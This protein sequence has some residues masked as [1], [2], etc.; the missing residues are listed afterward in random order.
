[1]NQRWNSKS[2][3]VNRNWNI[4]SD[5]HQETLQSRCLGQRKVW[6]WFLGNSNVVPFNLKSLTDSVPHKPILSPGPAVKYN[7]VV[8][9][10]TFNAHRQLMDEVMNDDRAQSY[11]FSE[12][13][14]GHQVTLL[15]RPITSRTESDA[16]AA[17]SEING[18]GNGD[19]GV[20]VGFFGSGLK[21]Y[22]C[23]PVFC[24]LQM[25]NQ[26]FWSS[27]T[28]NLSPDLPLGAGRIIQMLYCK[29]TFSSMSQNLDCW[30]VK[31]TFL[32]SLTQET[33]YW[34]TA[35]RWFQKKISRVKVKEEK[36]LKVEKVGIKNRIFMI[37]NKILKRVHTKRVFHHV[38]FFKINYKLTYCKCKTISNF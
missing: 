34:S 4:S 16:E 7:M 29:S 17:M 37:T 19:T 31:K 21:F 35:R 23:L 24:S 14:E 12:S 6:V 28:T 25:I 1:M 30:N 8:S 18:E 36:R 22:S 27:C 26:L 3:Y 5:L 32:P 38:G 10:T 2:F 33:N 9:G 11:R 13:S 20:L 15:F